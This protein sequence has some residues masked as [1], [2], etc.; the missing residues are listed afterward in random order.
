MVTSVTDTGAGLATDE[1]ARIFEEFY[2]SD[3]A[4]EESELGTGLGLPI[5]S[6]IVKIYQGTLRVD[7]APGKGSTFLIQ[8]PLAPSG[9]SA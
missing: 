8:L 2:R 3:F 1:V 6:Q 4:K 5:V 7:S 9:P